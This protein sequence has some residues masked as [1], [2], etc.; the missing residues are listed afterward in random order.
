MSVPS[1]IANN[2]NANV[3]VSINMG[4]TVL[5]NLKQTQKDLTLTVTDSSSKLPLYSWTFKGAD[6]AKSTETIKELNLAL[7]LKSVTA[8]AGVNKAVSAAGKGLLVTFGNNGNLP[9]PA[10][11][12]MF[13]VDQGFT[14]GQTVYL[15]YYNSDTKQIEAL[16]NSAYK[17]DDSGYVN[18]EIDHCSEYVLLPKQVAAVAPVR[19]DTGKTLKVK[20]GASYQFMVTASSK[21]SFTSANNSVFKVTANG[22]KGNHYY[23][24][25]TA[26]GKAGQSTGF[27]V[28]GEKA[29]RTVGTIVK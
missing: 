25:V 3:D 8:D 7:S 16:N 15:Y 14:A 27:Y 22:S 17:V 6:M 9:A 18:V 1:Q 11:V 26:V 12:K 23:F 4:K 21:P 29:P 19:L 5:E 28:N 24:K 2:T 20:A 13:V 10:T